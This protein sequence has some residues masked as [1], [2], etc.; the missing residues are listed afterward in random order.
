MVLIEAEERGFVF[1]SLDVD[2]KLLAGGFGLPSVE[3]II[4]LLQA[5]AVGLSLLVVETG[6]ARSKSD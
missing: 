5:A 6:E 1:K 4:S 3:R 2:C